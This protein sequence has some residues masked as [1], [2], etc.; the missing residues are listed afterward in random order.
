M[1]FLPRGELNGTGYKFEIMNCLASPG[2]MKGAEV[3]VHR[4]AGG[5]GGAG[6]RPVEKCSWN[7]TGD[8]KKKVVGEVDTGGEV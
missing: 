1:L 6:H 5:E 8:K 7:K 3:C 4:G 2:G